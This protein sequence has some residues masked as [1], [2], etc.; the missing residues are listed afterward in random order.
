MSS[1]VDQEVILFTKK[2]TLFESPSLEAKKV[3]DKSPTDETL[4]TKSLEMT[5]TTSSSPKQTR[6]RDESNQIDV[7]IIDENREKDSR[8]TSPSLKTTLEKK[9][10]IQINEVDVNES[11][12]ETSIRSPP[13]V[14]STPGKEANVTHT[15]DSLNVTQESQKSS[16]LNLNDLN[17]TQKS[18]IA[19]E[20]EQATEHSPKV[21]TV[22]STPVIQTTV[23]TTKIDK[24]APNEEV[25]INSDSSDSDA[26]KI[27]NLSFHFGYFKRYA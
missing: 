10:T 14:K 7:E 5:E 6:L 20:N 8:K 22:N 17:L 2:S 12:K 23:E 9:E 11:V 19:S 18:T 27:L 25:L 1:T 26:G 15:T 3:D 24:K 13:S 16:Y 21:Q 4:N